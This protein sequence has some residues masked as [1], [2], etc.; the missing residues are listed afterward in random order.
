MKWFL[1]LLAVAGLALAGCSNLTGPQRLVGAALC[2]AQC[3]MAKT[4][5]LSEGCSRIEVRTCVEVEGEDPAAY[6]ECVAKAGREQVLYDVCVDAV[7]AAY[8]GCVVGCNEAFKEPE[9]TPEE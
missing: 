3:P 4:V 9:P 6:A 5:A 8:T 7:D 1:V 2:R